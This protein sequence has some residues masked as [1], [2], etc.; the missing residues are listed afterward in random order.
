MGARQDHP[1]RTCSLGLSEVGLC[2]NNVHSPATAR[3]CSREMGGSVTVES[4]EEELA[5]GLG[6]CH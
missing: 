4:P 2:C 1:V 3:V 6:P 5:L